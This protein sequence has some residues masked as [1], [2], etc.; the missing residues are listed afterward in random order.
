[1]ELIKHAK[2]IIGENTR[3]CSTDSENKYRFL[4]GQPNDYSDNLL[5]IG[6]NPKS[7][8]VLWIGAN[9]S[10]AD[11]ELNDMTVKKIKR[12]T[13]KV[14]PGSGWLLM[15]LYPFRA[16]NPNDLPTE[17]DPVVEGINLAT[18]KHL[19]EVRTI[20]KVIFCWG[21]LALKHTV[22]KASK[23]KLLE[24]LPTDELYHL[25]ELTKKGEPKHPARLGYKTPLNKLNKDVSVSKP[26][27]YC[28]SN[29]T[30]GM[31]FIAHFCDNC[32]KNVNH[33]CDILL[34]SFSFEPGDEN[35][36]KEWVEINGKGTCTAFTKLKAKE[37]KQQ[38]FEREQ[39]LKQ[40]FEIYTAQINEPEIA[41]GDNWKV[42]LKENGEPLSFKEFKRMRVDKL[43]I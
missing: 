12:F 6:V 16:T 19:F 18:I 36:P 9:P 28:P 4:L 2:N 33:D 43:P 11:L 15:N 32:Q 35:Y 10:T 27:P 24:S 8:N 14:S 31:S 40:L 25:G 39:S 23:V 1:M 13:Q 5:W 37:G 7:D 42:I 41:Q 22:L 34:A 17:V 3:I 26:I 30:E 29:G 20:S 21:D 38:D